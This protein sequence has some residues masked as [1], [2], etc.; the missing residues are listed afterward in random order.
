MNT[1]VVTT[2]KKAE[3]LESVMSWLTN[4][5]E[6]APVDPVIDTQADEVVTK[7][8][9]T[10]PADAQKLSLNK[11]A[12]QN[13][14]GELQKEA[15]RRSAMLKQPVH[16][17]YEGATEGAPVANALVDLKMK[18]EEL[19]P[20]RY[21][22]EP[23]WA[24]RTLGR[25]PFVG[26]PL[27]RYFSKYE[28]SATQLD[29]IVRALRTGKE[30]L[31][32]DNITLADDQKAMRA[33]AEKLEKAVKLGQLIDAKLSTKLE[34]EL[35][36]GDARRAVVETE[37]LF[38]LRQRIQDLQ[39]QLIVNQQGIMAIDLIVRNNLELMRGVDRATHVTVSALQVAVT[40]ALA[41]A[42]QRVTLEKVLAV[43]ETT[44]RLIGQTAQ[45]LRTQGAEIHKLAAGTSLNIETLK[46]AFADVRAA[47]DD[48]ARFRQEA[49]PKMAEAIVELDKLADEAG[50]TIE[51]L[52]NARKVGTVL[53]KQLGQPE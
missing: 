37:W 46:Q 29:A 3:S 52:D 24:T 36:A 22:F 27:K 30:Q 33:L 47:L 40:L 6:P 44:D 11:Q 16:K 45:T 4:V 51:N 41:L 20:G 53:N 48:V 14:G 13:L 49:L 7:L 18:V 12:I 43:N 26:T 34:R 42:N 8:M 21:D 28:S 39:Q 35:T 50:R 5:A 23:G 31:N 25:L 9:T 38:P 32:R 1:N 15:A 10:D 2:E 19:D 17:L